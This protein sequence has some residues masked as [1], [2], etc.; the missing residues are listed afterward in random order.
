VNDIGQWGFSAYRGA[1]IAK[2][3]DVP[4][5]HIARPEGWTDEEWGVFVQEMTD[6]YNPE[7]VEEP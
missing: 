2:V 5:L 7:P 1:F 3:V 6:I 4:R